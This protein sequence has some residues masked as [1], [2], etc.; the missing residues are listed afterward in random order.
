[1]K[2]SEEQIEKFC[3][4]VDRGD[5]FSEPVDRDVFGYHDFV[6]AWISTQA[7]KITDGLW[8]PFEGKPGY[9][10]T[11]TVV[12]NAGVMAGFKKPSRSAVFEYIESCVDPSQPVT[13][14]YRPDDET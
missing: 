7:G 12:H 13:G 11:C 10:K 4:F 6:H 3:D 2:P 9:K 8:D 5:A 1:M 14:K